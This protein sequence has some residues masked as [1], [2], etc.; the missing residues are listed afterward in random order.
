M[1]SGDGEWTRLRF[2]PTGTQRR[3]S[4]NW[5]WHWHCRPASKADFGRKVSRGLSMTTLW[6]ALPRWALKEQQISGSKIQDVDKPLGQ[7]LVWPS[8]Y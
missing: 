8:L 6:S 1:N 2:L 7:T 3:T 5:H 4:P